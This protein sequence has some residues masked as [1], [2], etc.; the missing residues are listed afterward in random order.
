MYLGFFLD[1]NMDIIISTCT[2]NHQ[3]GL[4][5][6]DLCMWALRSCIVRGFIPEIYDLV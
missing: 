2:S 3:S 6:H 4:Y 1:V 5:P